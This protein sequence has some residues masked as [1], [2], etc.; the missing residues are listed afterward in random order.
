VL[1]VEIQCVLLLF[2]LK[3]SMIESGIRRVRCCNVGPRKRA[4]G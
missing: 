1:Q 4:H 2:E 3:L